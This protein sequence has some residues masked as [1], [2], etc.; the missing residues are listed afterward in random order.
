MF[1]DWFQ[2]RTSVACGT[3]DLIS[4]WWENLSITCKSNPFPIHWNGSPPEWAGFGR[5]IWTL[6]AS[7]L[8]RTE[9]FTDNASCSFTWRLSSYCAKWTEINCLDTWVSGTILISLSFMHILR[10]ERDICMFCAWVRA[11]SQT[12]AAVGLL[13]QAARGLPCSATSSHVCFVKMDARGTLWT[14]WLSEI[15][16]PFVIWWVNHMYIDR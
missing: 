7:Y 2:S 5:S 3:G 13:V 16:P 15:S 8:P 1:C 10:W 6:L 4:Y 14:K 9:M 11:V 12:G